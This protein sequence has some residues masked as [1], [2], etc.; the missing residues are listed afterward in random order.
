MNT[1]SYIIYTIK[2]LGKGIFAA[3]IASFGILIGHFI[4]LVLGFDLHNT[5]ILFDNFYSIVIF[6]C[7]SVVT[8]ILIG[9]LFKKLNQ[10]FMEKFLTIFVYH[11]FFFHVLR[12]V[13]EFLYGIKVTI[14]SDLICHL[15]P[16]LFFSYF[17]ALLWNSDREPISIF[18]QLDNYLQFFSKKKWIIKFLIGWFIFL[19]IYYLANRLIGPFVEPFY[20]DL[21]NYDASVLSFY[22]MFFLKI[23]IG[24]LFLITL[25]PIFILWQESKTSLLFWLGFP[26]FVQAAVFPSIVE[27]WLP[28]GMR[29]PYLIQYTVITYLIAIIFVQLFY[30]PRD[31]DNIDDQFK[32]MY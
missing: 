17:V 15:T 21:S 28:L 32:W 2:S 9:E 18:S 7:S 4:G 8:A 27:L 29:F 13:D 23:I 22:S 31:N 10:P 5:P 26:I 3:T 11:F 16:A 1:G 24:A 6:F 25:M 20:S 14:L 19:P 30:V 12:A